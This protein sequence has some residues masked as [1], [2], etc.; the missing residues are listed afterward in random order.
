MQRWLSVRGVKAAMTTEAQASAAIGAAVNK[1]ATGTPAKRA[2]GMPALNVVLDKLLGNDEH[3]SKTPQQKFKVVQERLAKA[4]VAPEAT[5]DGV[6]ELLRPLQQ[7]SE[8]L[9]DMAETVLGVQLSYLQSIMPKDPGTNMVLGKSYWQPT[10]RELYEFSLGAAGVLFPL[11][12]IEAISD[13][14]VPPQAAEAV[15]ATNPEL[16]M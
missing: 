10:D 1:V 16:L 11:D 15:A 2:R 12:T 5:L 14:L 13:G 3:T 9:A 8:Q 6:Y 7:V 4:T